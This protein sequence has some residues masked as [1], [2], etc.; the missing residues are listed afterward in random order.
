MIKK[1]LDYGKVV[2]QLNDDRLQKKNNKFDFLSGLSVT[3]KGISST[4]NH[5]PTPPLSDHEEALQLLKFITGKFDQLKDNCVWENKNN[6]LDS[7]T[8][9]MQRLLINLSKEWLEQQ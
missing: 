5:E 9:K 1:I 8:I 7:N 6:V 2:K 4:L 3:S